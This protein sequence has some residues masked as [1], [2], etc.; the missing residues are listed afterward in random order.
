MA[1]G[2]EDFLVLAINFM[3]L[4]PIKIAFMEMIYVY[5]KTKKILN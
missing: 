5:Y 1:G 4:Y 2:L 3:L